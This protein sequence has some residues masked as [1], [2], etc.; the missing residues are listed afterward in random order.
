MDIEKII[1]IKENELLKEENV[2]LK[3]L[4]ENYIN[5]RG[6]CTSNVLWRLKSKNPKFNN[7]KYTENIDNVSV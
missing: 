7:Y 4:L 2:K 1:L 5:S 6:L 3:S